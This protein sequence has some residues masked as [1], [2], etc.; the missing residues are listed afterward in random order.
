LGHRVT[1]VYL[2]RGERGIA[3]KSLG[4]AAAIRTKEAES[5]CRILRA[6]PLFAGQID[7]AT[8][9]NKSRIESFVKLLSVEEPDLVFT[10]WPIDTHLDHQI[11][12]MLAY[13]AC[14]ASSGRFRLYFFEVNLG[15]QTQ[16]FHPTDYVDIT[17]VREKKK[18]AL[19]A[20]K[21]QDGE[22][23]YRN[24]HQVMEGFR[25]RESGVPAAEA[26]VQLARLSSTSRLPGL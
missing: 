8:E 13:R 22:G 21:S 23:I 6:R 18:A 19:F 9:L 2:T 25:G 17:T 26:F 7:G 5:A 16:G 10:H 24:Y 1:V 4:E 20:H 12:S 15:S 14:H 11:A 3:G